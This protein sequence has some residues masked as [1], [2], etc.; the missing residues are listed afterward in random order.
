MMRSM[1]RPLRVLIACE[2]SQAECTAFR[3]AGHEAFSCDLQ[4]CSGGHPEWHVVGD[5]LDLFEN[6]DSFVTQDGKQ[7]SASIG[8]DLIISHPP[9]TYLT[10]SGSNWLFDAQ[11]RIKDYE[12]WAMLLEAR[13]FFMKCYAA[14]ARY[15][16]VENPMPMKV[17]KLPRRSC[18]VQ[19]Y[20]FGE[21]WSKCTWLWLRNLPP[22]I[23]TIWVDSYR[24]WVH[25]TR[26]SKKRSKSFRGIARAMAIQWSAFIIEDMARN[27]LL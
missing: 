2:E 3:D 27:H 14:P 25:C 12:R 5:C 19:P 15:V 18:V 20:E 11:H 1:N 24:S 22:L 23:P 4:P 26:D 21:P 17:A 8:W 7:H 16:A 9:C 13:D 6:P 10:K